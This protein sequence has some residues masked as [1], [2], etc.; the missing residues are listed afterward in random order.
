[1]NLLDQVEVQ[2]KSFTALEPAA[3]AS[4]S[5]RQIY[6]RSRNSVLCGLSLFAI[7]FAGS[8]A[9]SGGNDAATIEPDDSKVHVI[10]F[11][12]FHRF[13]DRH[14]LILMEF[15][16]PWWCVIASLFHEDNESIFNKKYLCDI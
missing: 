3:V 16:A 8:Y 15:Y 6:P 14:P 13:I 9:A 12:K 7:L 10:T 4:E 5:V 11:D 2:L 1:M